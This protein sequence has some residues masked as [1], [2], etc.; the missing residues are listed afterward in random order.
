MNKEKEIQ[1]LGIFYSE[2]I[3]GA[4]TDELLVNSTRIL[5]CKILNILN[6][7]TLDEMDAVIPQLL[8]G[9]FL[10]L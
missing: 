6:N 7:C 10:S 3:S 2:A 1:E 9:E 5:G 4:D 8:S